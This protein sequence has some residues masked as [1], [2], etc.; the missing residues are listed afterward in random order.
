MEKKLISK[1][2]YQRRAALA[3]TTKRANLVAKNNEAFKKLSAPQKRVAIAQDVIK[4]IQLKRY[5]PTKGDYVL[6]KNSQ[7]RFKSIKTDIQTVFPEIENCNTCAMGACILSIAHL[8]DHLNGKDVTERTD[9]A[10]K[11]IKEFFAPK[12]L[13]LIETAFEMTYQL[14]GFWSTS[15][16]GI[17]SSNIGGY[18]NA[19]QRNIAINFGDKYYTDEERMIA[20]Y[21]NI[22]DNKGTFI[23]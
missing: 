11:M 13:A 19:A 7:S 12:Q 18:L 9:A 3:V 21:Q 22:I 8:N 16:G 17:H 14:G 10:T 4:Q 5:K 6:F 2:E 1:E 20:I 15:G 23:P